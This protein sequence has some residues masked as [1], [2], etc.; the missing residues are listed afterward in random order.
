MKFKE[1]ERCIVVAH[2]ISKEEVVGILSNVD[3]ASNE[4]T[5][6]QS[7][8]IEYNEDKS[9]G[10]FIVTS[11]PFSMNAN[12]EQ[13]Y[14]FSMDNVLFCSLPNLDTVS[15]YV[16]SLKSFGVYVETNGYNVLRYD[17][18]EMYLQDD[19]EDSDTEVQPKMLL[20]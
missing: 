3:I 13:I 4:I 20:Q 8:I 10:N 9:T 17:D 19:E 15:A 5:I 18:S 2:L 1:L 12:N 11:K 6:R 14:T 16:N 7:R